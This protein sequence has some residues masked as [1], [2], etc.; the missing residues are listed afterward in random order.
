[1]MAWLVKQVN[2]KNK[3]FT[4]I[5]MVVVLAIIAIL[6]A[7]AVPQVLRQINRAKINADKANARTIA[8]A[9]QQYVG[10]GYT[11]TQTNPTAINGSEPWVTQY[12]TGGVP[13]VRYNSSWQFYYWTDT[14]GN[15]V[16]VGAGSSGSDAQNNEL[17][18]ELKGVYANP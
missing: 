17:Y 4:L 2:K 8:T 12:M 5:E 10:D 16:Y 1:M 3:G 9:I 18:P 7:I 14:T 13:K 11:V 15:A 6:I